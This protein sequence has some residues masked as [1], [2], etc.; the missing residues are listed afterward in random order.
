MGHARSRSS[1]SAHPEA[2]FLEEKPDQ[3]KKKAKTK[4]GDIS[5]EVKKGTF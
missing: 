1:L 2:K 4:K 5:I 3:K